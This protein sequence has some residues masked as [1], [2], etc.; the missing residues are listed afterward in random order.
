ME[1]CGRVEGVTARKKN[2]TRRNRCLSVSECTSGLP[3]SFSSSNAVR[4]SLR[5]ITIA[6][7]V[8]IVTCHKIVL[9]DALIIHM[10]G[11]AE[12]SLRI[13]DIYFT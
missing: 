7:A 13:T 1:G 5:D 12:S 9:P 10:D 4:I 6:A 3:E 11:Y 2:C 8:A